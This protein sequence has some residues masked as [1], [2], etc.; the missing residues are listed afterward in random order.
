[1]NIL[2]YITQLN[3]DCYLDLVEKLRRIGVSYFGA[4][5]FHP[6][7]RTPSLVADLKLSAEE[8]KEFRRSVSGYAERTGIWIQVEDSFIDVSY[9]NE[10][11]KKVIG[12]KCAVLTMRGKPAIDA[13]GDVYPCVL[14]WRDQNFVLGNVREGPIEKL[15]ARY[16]SHWVS[17]HFHVSDVCKGCSRYHLCGGGCPAYWLDLV[18][19][20]D[21][22]CETNQ[23]IPI[24]PYPDMRDV[25][26]E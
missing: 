23:Y 16:T 7:L 3:K 1:M 15:W 9:A 6:R 10:H 12:S 25:K 8:W 11:P 19:G 21:Y 5:Q 17:E 4:T 24:C 13:N 14:L 22:R 2:T 26:G 18:D 20:V